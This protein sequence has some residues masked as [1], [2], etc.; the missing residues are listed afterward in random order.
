MGFPHA[1]GQET[2]DA[3]LSKNSKLVTCEI[4]YP[5]IDNIFGFDEEKQCDDSKLNE[6]I[7]KTDFSNNFK[8]VF[9]NIPF[10]NLAVLIA[11]LLRI[12]IYE[13]FIKKDNH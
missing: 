12:N 9:K 7:Y 5:I 10:V 1:Y 2:Q 6:F 3:F 11:S 4:N 13:Y 8:F